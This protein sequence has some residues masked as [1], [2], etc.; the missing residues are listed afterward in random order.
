MLT[1]LRPKNSPLGGDKIHI[2]S[3]GRM[4]KF[5]AMLFKKLSKNVLDQLKIIAKIIKNDMH[6]SSYHKQYHKF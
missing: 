2:L 3:F 4:R 6:N 1:R 5:F